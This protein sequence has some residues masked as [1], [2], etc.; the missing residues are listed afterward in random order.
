MFSFSDVEYELGKE[1]NR[2]IFADRE[3]GD[4]GNSSHSVVPRE[5]KCSFP[6]GRRSATIHPMGLQSCYGSVTTV[7]PLSCLLIGAAHGGLLFLIY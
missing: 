3:L 1:D 7:N 6:Q 4:M 2:N 5:Q